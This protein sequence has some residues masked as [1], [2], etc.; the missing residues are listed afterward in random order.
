LVLIALAMAVAAAIGALIA[1]THCYS[2][3]SWHS[4]SVR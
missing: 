2:A 4:R 1:A 3:P